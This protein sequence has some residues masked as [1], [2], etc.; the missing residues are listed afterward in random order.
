MNILDILIIYLSQL[1]LS[2]QQFYLQ[3]S[4][5]STDKTSQVTPVLIKTQSCELGHF[6]NSLLRNF[7]RPILL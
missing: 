2:F 4:H 7:L 1:H 3:M 6:P 5:P